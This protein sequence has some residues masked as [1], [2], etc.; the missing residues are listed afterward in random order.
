MVLFCQTLYN[1]NFVTKKYMEKGLNINEWFSGFNVY[2]EP[3][4]I[5]VTLTYWAFFIM[6]SH[7]SFNIQLLILNGYLSDT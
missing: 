1:L 4:E 5:F 7:L 2:D 3:H 6:V